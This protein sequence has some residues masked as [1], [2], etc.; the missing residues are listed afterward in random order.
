MRRSGYASGGTRDRR[1][2]RDLPLIQGPG[3][4][5]RAAGCA[6]LGLGVG[7]CEPVAD[8]LG[9]GQ[10]TPHERYVESLRQAGLADRALGAAWIAAAGRA[11]AEPLPVTLPFRETG[12]FPADEALARGYRI[13]TRRGEEIVVSVESEAGGPAVLFVDL[14]AVEPDE[15][16]SFEQLQSIDSNITVIRHAT[17]KDGLLIVR[18][19]PE[20]LRPVRYTVTMQVEPTLAFPV[21][22]HGTDAIRS[23]FGVDRD[24]GRRSHHGVDI[25]APRGTA[26]LAAAEGRA[27]A[28]TNRLGG[29]VV[30]QRVPGLGALYYAHLDSQAFT[31]ERVVRPGD[32]VGFVGN[33]GN[34]VT[35]P[36][37][38]HFG[39]YARPGGPVDPFPFLYEPEAEPLEGLGS[40]VPLGGLARTTA[41]RAILRDA[42]DVGASRLDTLPAGTIMRV[43]AGAG[44]WRRI[45]LPDGRTGFLRA[46]ELT[47]AGSETPLAATE[48]T[49]PVTLRLRPDSG[50]M[51]IADLGPGTPIAVLGRFDDWQL[52]ALGGDVRLPRSGTGSLPDRG[53]IPVE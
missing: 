10:G 14:F 41:R 37:H 39:I 23:G 6:A 16:P 13:A 40:D 31:G 18:L 4:L 44:N 38:L 12:F 34:V 52:V 53:W 45:D 33:T 36:P 42:P 7:A 11:L 22:G 35:T 8:L 32:T 25:F 26:V 15:G 24:G 9:G 43:V 28:G 46:A 1:G 50:S 51:A 49:S 29:N 5:L 47:D 21:E 17:D 3:A 27:E 48:L 20:L 2:M 30:W 19:Q